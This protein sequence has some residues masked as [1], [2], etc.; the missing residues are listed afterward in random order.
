MIPP[1][2][3]DRG[4]VR[5]ALQ[6]A[7]GVSE[8]LRVD[9]AKRS[10]GGSRRL[11]RRGKEG[12]NP[13]RSYGGNLRP[14]RFPTVHATDPRNRR[15]LGSALTAVGDRASFFSATRKGPWRGSRDRAARGGAGGRGGGD[16]RYHLP[17]CCHSSRRTPKR[18]AS[19]P[20]GSSR[21]WP[22]AGMH[23]PRG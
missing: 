23:K 4:A 9:P 14:P 8:P 19:S 21:W 2:R 18:P 3:L 12:E 10:V 16:G 1:R 17:G 22:E 20:T 15:S 6:W 5:L 13:R 11:D 7:H